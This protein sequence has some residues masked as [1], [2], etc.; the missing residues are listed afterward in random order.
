MTL[1]RETVQAMSD[2]ELLAEA[3]MKR[4]P[5][6]SR[7]YAKE[8]LLRI[9]RWGTCVDCPDKDG[10]IYGQKRGMPLTERCPNT[11]RY[12]HHIDWTKDGKFHFDS[13]DITREELIEF[14]LT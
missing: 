7:Y 9:G 5:H 6:S 2:N 8:T 1:N 11:D 10:N 4:S 3:V 14:L 12:D 13:K